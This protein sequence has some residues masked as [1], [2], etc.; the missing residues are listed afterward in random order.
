MFH[1]GSVTQRERTCTVKLMNIFE[2]D[3]IEYAIFKDNLILYVVNT[4]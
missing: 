2:Y 4:I 1:Y 3:R